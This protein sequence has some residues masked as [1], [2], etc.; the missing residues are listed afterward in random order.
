MTVHKSFTEAGLT[1]T[2]EFD[3]KGDPKMFIETEEISST[4]RP[5]LTTIEAIDERLN[6]IQLKEI[7]GKETPKFKR[8]DIPRIFFT[9]YGLSLL[10]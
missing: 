7:E 9:R 5:A 3:T 1:H 6:Q 2:V 8:P 4:P 10:R